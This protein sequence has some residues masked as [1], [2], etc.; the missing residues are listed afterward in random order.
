MTE[1]EQ[2][3]L[4]AFEQLSAQYS[5]DMKRLEAQNSHLQKQLEVLSEQVQKLAKQQ[6]TLMDA[7]NEE[8][9]T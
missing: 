3:L 9:S 4:T 8:Y 7:L 6:R 5:G 2:Q 1:L